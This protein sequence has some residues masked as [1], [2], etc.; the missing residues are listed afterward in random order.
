LGVFRVEKYKKVQTIVGLKKDQIV[1]DVFFVKFKK[2]VEKYKNGYK[3]ELKI[4]DSSGEI[5]M[6]YWGEDSEQNVKKIYD[7]IKQDDVI[8]INGRVNEWNEKLEISLNKD[9]MIKVCYPEQYNTSDF[10]KTSEKDIEIMFKDLLQVIDSIKDAHLKKILDYFFNDIEFAEKFKQCPAAMYNHHGW[11]GGLLEHVLNIINICEHIAKIHPTLNRD[12]LVTGAILHDI[13]KIEE[14]STSTHIRVTNKGILIGHVTI[15]AQ[16]L[17]RAFDKIDIPEDY[18]LKVMHMVLSHHGKME[19][20]S[21]K[22]P[23]FPEALALYYADE[24]DARIHM[25]IVAKENSAT[26][27]DYVYTKEFGNVYLK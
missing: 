1:N 4:G 2:P 17:G 22:I 13:G 21:P 23:A 27:D 12:L 20:G 9:N 11:I 6:K 3:F 25:M 7:S 16:M 5:M 18:K 8:F 14:L 24:F 15:G 10:I 19:Y 26:E